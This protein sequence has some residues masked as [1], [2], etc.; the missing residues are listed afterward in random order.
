M[1][2]FWLDFKFIFQNTDW[3]SEMKATIEEAQQYLTPNGQQP[4]LTPDK[5]KAAPV[6]SGWD[7][8]TDWKPEEGYN[9]VFDLGDYEM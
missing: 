8:N 4:E 5:P 3:A 7:E 2:Q 1:G 9:A 6:W